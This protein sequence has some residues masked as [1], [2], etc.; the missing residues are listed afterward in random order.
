[1]D[2]HGAALVDVLDD[3]V[4]IRRFR[5]QQRSHEL[6]RIVGLQVRGLIRDDGV[7][8]GVRFVEAVARK[9]LHE[10]EDTIRL[11]VRYA[12]RLGPVDEL[13]AL[14]RHQFGVLLS[15]GPAQDIRLAQAEAREVRG[16]PHDLFLIH[17][18]PVRFLEDR[19]HERVLVLDLGA[20]MLA[21]DEFRNLL[22]GAR[23]IHRHQR[24]DVFD[25]GGPELS[26]Q[27][28]HAG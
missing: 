11:L 22:H 18:D 13:L 10:A 21:L 25:I 3:L 8:G 26:E 27:V 23:P 6:H 17:H 28:A 19:L 1:M 15:H 9:L 16:N 20:A 4:R 12:A 7:C 24:D 2:A 14:V 5:G